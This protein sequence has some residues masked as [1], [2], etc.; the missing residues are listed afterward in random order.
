MKKLIISLLVFIPLQIV[1]GQDKIITIQHDTIFCRIVSVSA[2]HIQ[3]E[4]KGENQYMVGKFIPTEQVFEYYRGGSFPEIKPSYRANKRLNGP[5]RRR[6]IGMN[7]GGSYLLASTTDAEKELIDMGMPKS[8]VT[9]YYR[10][11]KRGWHFSGEIHYLLFEYFGLGVTYTLFTSSTQKEFKIPVPSVSG[12]Q[13]LSLDI[14]EREYIH[15]A[16]PSVMFRQWLDK[17]RRL[18]LTETLSAGFVHYRDKMRMGS[19]NAIINALAKS[20]TWGTKAD[21]SLCY[22]GFMPK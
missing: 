21:L 7:A 5:E 18:Q 16:A 8:D 15:Y 3:Y 12:F 10:Q 20:N 17:N 1:N 13:Y 2:T 19:T 6:S 22:Y 14:K 11:F 9:D 4:Q